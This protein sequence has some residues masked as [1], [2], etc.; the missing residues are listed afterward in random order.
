MIKLKSIDSYLADENYTMA[1]LIARVGFREF[2]RNWTEW[3][4]KHFLSPAGN[5]A[6]DVKVA[7]EYCNAGQNCI[8]LLFDIARR[9]GNEIEM[10]LALDFLAY[11]ERD[12]VGSRAGHREARYGFDPEASY[13]TNGRVE[14]MDGGIGYF[15]EYSLLRLDPGNQKLRKLEMEAYIHEGHFD[16]ALQ[17]THGTPLQAE[18]ERLVLELAETLPH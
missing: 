5:R 3:K 4:P 17:V 18:T 11:F 15:A 1:G 9:A 8:V 10:Y 12:V 7:N 13:L 14:I 6:S 2:R 16:G